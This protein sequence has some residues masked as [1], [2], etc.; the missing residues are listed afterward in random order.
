VPLYTPI[1]DYHN[2][3]IVN[4]VVIWR[5]E[6]KQTSESIFPLPPVS[7]TG[8]QNLIVQGFADGQSSFVIAVYVNC[9][10]IGE[11]TASNVAT[12]QSITVS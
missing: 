6:H 11:I 5:Y 9:L 2:D 10:K 7:S 12:I 4:V 8:K 3:Y 1:K